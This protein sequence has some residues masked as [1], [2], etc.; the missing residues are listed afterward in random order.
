MKYIVMLFILLS[1]FYT[2]S[3]AS[4][5][6]RTKNRMAAVGAALM[7]LVSIIIPVILMFFR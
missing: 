3:F 2:F 5:N 4:Y 1:A 6:W 7:S